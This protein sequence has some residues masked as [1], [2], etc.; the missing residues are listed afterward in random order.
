MITFLLVYFILKQQ[1]LQV[2]KKIFVE[3]LKR[4]NLNFLSSQK[5]IQSVGAPHL[6]N[7]SLD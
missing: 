4:Y 2:K 7:L 3:E 6:I 1:T 5:R